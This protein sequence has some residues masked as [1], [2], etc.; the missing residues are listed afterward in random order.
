[1]KKKAIVWIVLAV[2]AVACV[3]AV[4]SKQKS[5]AEGIAAVY[6]T[7]EITLEAVEQYRE[8]AALAGGEAPQ[9]DRAVVDRLLRN[10]ILLE[11]A[12]KRGIAATE[13]EIQAQLDATKQWYAENEEV[14]QRT[15]YY[16]ASAGISFEEYLRIIEELLPETIAR[17]KFIDAVGRQEAEKMVTEALKNVTYY[18]D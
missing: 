4:V 7:H 16:C 17:A 14:K 13:A 6:G 1:M 18:V 5:D 11:E 3:I 9:S 2:V 15:D 10:L 8:N 12:E